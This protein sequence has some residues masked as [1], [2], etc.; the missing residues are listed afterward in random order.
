MSL[1]RIGI[2][3]RRRTTQ[4]AAKESKRWQV[5][6]NKTVKDQQM[7]ARRGMREMLVFWKRNEREERDSRKKAEKEALDALK[8]EEEM[9][10]AKR[11]GS[12][13]ELPHHPD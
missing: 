4:L 2:L 9:R 12:K 11:Q 8:R 1:D 3:T 6:S 10:E 7:K 5:R 13:V